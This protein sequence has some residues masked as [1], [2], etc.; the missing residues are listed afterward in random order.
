[1]CFLFTLWRINK[2]NQSINNG[3]PFVKRLMFVKK[4]FPFAEN[5]SKYLEKGSFKSQFK[6]KP[7]GLSI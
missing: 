5:N 1:M 3:L 2:I 7:H 4:T 6:T